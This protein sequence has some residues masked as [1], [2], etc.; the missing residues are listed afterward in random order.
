MN[1]QDDYKLIWSI[2]RPE[3]FTAT[4]TTCSSQGKPKMA[5]KNAGRSD[6]CL[7]RYSS[8]TEYAGIMQ[9]VPSRRQ[10]VTDPSNPCLWG[11]ALELW[12]SE[13]WQYSLKSPEFNQ[14]QHLHVHARE[15]KASI[16]VYCTRICLWSAL[17]GSPFD[18]PFMYQMKEAIRLLLL[19]TCLLHPSRLITNCGS[20]TCSHLH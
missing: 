15:Y 10:K 9:L 8:L 11:Q 6:V 16:Y 4:C 17:A 5:N 19:K 18:Q 20:S 3:A 2:W 1:S 7:R 14:V 12:A 13:A